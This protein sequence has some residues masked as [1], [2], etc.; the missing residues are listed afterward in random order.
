LLKWDEMR[1]Q[2]NL[3][4][5][6]P[7]A[8]QQIGTHP[9]WRAAVDQEVRSLGWESKVRIE[10]PHLGITIGV[11]DTVI[12]QDTTFYPEGPAT[13]SLSIFLDGRGTLSVV[14][15]KP[16]EISP[17]MAAVFSSKG[18]CKGENF[19]PGGQRLNTV[20][21][22]FERHL[23]LEAGGPTLAHLGGDLLTQ[24]SLPEEGVCLVGFPASTSM[25]NAARSLA[26]CKLDAGLARRLF[27]Y[28]R[29]I[30]CLGI[31]VTSLQQLPSLAG[32][33]LRPEDRRRI[34]EARHLLETKFGQGWTIT[35]LSREV[36]LNERKLKH[37]FRM[38][39]GI[40]VH[41]YLLR[42][43]MDAAATLLKSGHTVTET[44]FAV[45]FESLSHFSR[46]FSQTTGVT[47]SKFAKQY[48]SYEP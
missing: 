24:H 21:L 22:R 46:A 40:T 18:Y 33:A 5:D 4:S 16:L 29:A 39:V 32:P 31:A 41:A 36:A 48:S 26:S 7:S 17:G 8:P 3:N 25:L 13:F 45:G 14:G 30:E 35:R 12:E 19:L 1:E 9:N 23:L 6:A 42:V 27:F 2:D 47:P 28:S 37:G 20:D 44:A 15:A 10:Q 38:L 43:R 11:L 34:L